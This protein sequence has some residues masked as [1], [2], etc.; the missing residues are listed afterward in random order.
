[1]RV[2]FSRWYSEGRE[3]RYGFWWELVNFY[4]VNVGYVLVLVISVNDSE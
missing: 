1:M 3:F 2:F 4:Y